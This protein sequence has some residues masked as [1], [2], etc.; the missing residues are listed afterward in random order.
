M[1]LTA[2]KAAPMCPLP[3][4]PEVFLVSPFV[5]LSSASTAHPQAGVYIAKMSVFI[6]VTGSLSQLVQIP[7]NLSEKSLLIT[8]LSSRVPEISICPRGMRPGF[9]F[10]RRSRSSCVFPDGTPPALSC[11]WFSPHHSFILQIRWTVPDSG[12]DSLQLLPATSG[13]CRGCLGRVHSVQ[14]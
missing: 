6:H 14:D 4:Y 9:A 3:S 12:H 11:S 8:E 7:A 10:D 5:P 1:Q 13:C 2:G